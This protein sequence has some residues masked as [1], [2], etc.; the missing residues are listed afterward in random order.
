MTNVGRSTGKATYMTVR[1]GGGDAAANIATAKSW[2]V[3]DV[4]CVVHATTRESTSASKTACV[5]ACKAT[6][7]TAESAGMAAASESAG[8]GAT[9]TTMSTATTAVLSK[10]GGACGQKCR[11]GTDGPQ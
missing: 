10:C 9:T 6:V 3:S 2:R 1:M 5:A 11:Q 8:M 4:R 7:A